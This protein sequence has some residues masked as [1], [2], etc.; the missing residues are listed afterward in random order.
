MYTLI[1]IVTSF[2]RRFFKFRKFTIL[3]QKSWLKA[4]FGVRGRPVQY[5]KC[6]LVLKYMGRYVLVLVTVEFGVGVQ[7]L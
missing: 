5:D 2:I 3:G 1:L 6:G 7:S 4:G